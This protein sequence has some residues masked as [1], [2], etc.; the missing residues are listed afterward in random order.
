MMA[1]R[2]IVSNTGPLI[3]LEKLRHGYDFI[4]QLYDT[5]IIPPGVLDEV[6]EGQFATPHAYV[7]HYGIVDLIEI[8]AVSRSEQLPEAT[9]LHIGEVQAIQLA[10]E[11]A[12]PL[13]IEETVG[14]RV[15]QGLGI[16]ISGIAGQIL[17]VFRQGSLTAQEA[18]NKLLELLQAGRIN[19]KIYE[20][21]LVGIP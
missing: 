19:R 17:K 9:R 13:L 16:S 7:Q 18:R 4:R 6:A 1:V 5:I 12:L 14:R 3:S 10:R 20:A 2:R 11:L 15:A 8:H 21:L